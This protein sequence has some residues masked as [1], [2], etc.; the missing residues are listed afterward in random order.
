MPHARVRFPEVVLRAGEL[1]AQDVASTLAAGA[2]LRAGEI[3][4]AATGTVPER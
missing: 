3:A 1:N 4:A 2:E